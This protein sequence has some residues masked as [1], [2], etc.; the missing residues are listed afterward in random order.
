MTTPQTAL[1]SPG[2]ERAG[3]ERAGAERAGAERAGAERAGAE[4]AGAE[5]A[6]AERAGAVRAGGDGAVGAAWRLEAACR[7]LPTD[8]FFPI[9]QG[10][11]AQA[12]IR[13]A[14]E[15]CNVCP[16]RA[17]CGE[18]AL[19]ANMQYGVFGG[20]TEEERRQVRRRIRQGFGLPDGLSDGALEESA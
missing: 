19:T 12:Q 11:L 5:R 18:Y 15:I 10:P 9:G 2:A 17:R 3:A 14:K 20:M 6:G 4:R 13:L 16:V 7:Q 1:V 8:L